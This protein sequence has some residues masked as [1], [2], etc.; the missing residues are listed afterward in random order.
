M[1]PITSPAPPA[2]LSLLAVTFAEVPER[3]RALG[4]FGAVG[5]VA[6]TFGVVAGGLIAAGPGWRWAFF[7]DV[8][9]GVVMIGLATAFLAFSAFF[10]CIFLGTLLMQQQLG[11]SP[12]ETGLA[13]LATTATEF[14]TACVT[15]RMAAAVG[16]RRLLAVGLALLTAGMLWL[17]Q[18]PADAGFLGDLLA[19]FL[20]AGPGFGSAGPRYRS[21]RCPGSAN[22]NR[23]WP[24][25]WS[26]RCA[27]SVRPLGSRQ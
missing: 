19:A 21:A 23:E 12:I 20:L 15:G 7:I 24:P 11:Y 25:A 10:S 26:K 17:T 8:P 22:R 6:G 16:I 2:A 9:A 27:R 3:N 14:V 18:V 5:A 4:I 13:W 1:S